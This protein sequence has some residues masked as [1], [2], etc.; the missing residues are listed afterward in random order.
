MWVRAVVSHDFWS[1]L[2]GEVF[3]AGKGEMRRRWISGGI[4]GRR[5]NQA[6]QLQRPPRFTC[7]NPGVTPP[8]VEHCSP[9]WEAS[10]LTTIPS[11]PRGLWNICVKR[12]RALEKKKEL[13]KIWGS[14]C[15]TGALPFPSDC[16]CNLC[17]RR[18]VS[19]PEIREQLNIDLTRTC[20]RGCCERRQPNFVRD[21]RGCLPQRMRGP[22]NPIA[23][24]VA[25]RL[26]CSPP[27][28]ACFSGISRPN[29]RVL[30]EYDS[31]FPGWVTPDSRMRES[32][33][34]M[35]LAGGFSRRPPVP[36]THAFRL[37]YIPT[38]SHPHLRSRSHC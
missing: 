3:G 9:W 18:A 14:R 23:A 34:T 5:E 36:P 17:H 25:E 24:T 7:E 32:C 30:C 12:A 38:S 13:R 33:R 31:K 6:G 4:Q 1:A 2:N 10:S 29:K 26:D 21:G 22:Q 20:E 35:P 15:N 8:G 27:T 19:L 11:R 28:K 16:Q 37:R